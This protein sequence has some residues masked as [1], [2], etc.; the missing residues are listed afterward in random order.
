MVLSYFNR[1]RRIY[2]S[3]MA[4]ISRHN[5]QDYRVL[6]TRGA[7]GVVNTENILDID[8]SEIEM[9]LGRLEYNE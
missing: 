6:L 8:K 5:C 4:R 3:W 9:A 7:Y 2:A 1:Y